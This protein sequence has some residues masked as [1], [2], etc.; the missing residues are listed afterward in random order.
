MTLGCGHTAAFCKLAAAGGGPT[1]QATLKDQQGMVNV[2]AIKK[3]AQFAEMIEQGW[4]WDVCRH[5]VDAAFPGFAKLA[6]KALNVSNHVATA[7]SELETAVTL[8]ET[9]Q[10]PGMQEVSDWKELALQNVTSLGVPCAGYAKSILEFAILFGGGQGTPFIK[11]MDD[12]AKTFQCNV[13]LGETFWSA[14]TFTA[15]P[16]QT[17]KFPMIRVAAA[18]ANLTSDKVEDGIAKLL[19]KTDIEGYTSGS[20]IC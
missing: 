2:A 12:F 1:P 4:G 18:V 17:C 19:V 20:N 3:N 8:A 9:A 6:Q 13:N 10:D 15:F 14:I 7:C 5:E 11:F 16:D